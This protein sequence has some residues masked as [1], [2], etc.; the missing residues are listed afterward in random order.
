MDDDGGINVL[1]L[2]KH[3]ERV[4]RYDLVEPC[5]ASPAVSVGQVLVRGFTNLFC[6][7]KRKS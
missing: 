1:R 6:F 4:A 7:G 3:F 5:Y 2:G